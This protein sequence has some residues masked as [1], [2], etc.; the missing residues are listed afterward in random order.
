MNNIKYLLIIF[1]YMILIFFL[2]LFLLFS[3]NYKY[4]IRR[5]S[6]NDI[7]IQINNKSNKEYKIYDCFTYFQESMMLYI[8]LFRLNKYIDKFIIIISNK[9]FSGKVNNISFKPYEKEIMK[10]KNK[11]IFKTVNFPISFNRNGDREKYTRDS[12]YIF[13]KEENVNKNDIILISDI[14]EI[15]TDDG[16]KYIINNPPTNPISFSGNYYIYNYRNLVNGTWVGTIAYRGNNYENIQMLRNKRFSFKRIPFLSLS[17]C[18]FCYSSISHYQK[19]LSSFKQNEYSGYPFIDTYY[20]KNKI[21]NHEFLYDRT[22]L[23]LVDY[24]KSINPLP[25][26]VTL[27]FLKDEYNVIG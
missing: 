2:I 1:L 15:P 16:M 23:I 9:T 8:R 19:K 13:L 10:Y 3:N 21:K 22:K 27:N 26:D 7:D 12:I 11:I 18:S 17:H 4:N 5:N 25:N 20:I 14:D 24:N 6:S